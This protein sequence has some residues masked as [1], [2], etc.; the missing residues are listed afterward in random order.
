[1]TA[2]R[3]CSVCGCVE[4]RAC[5]GGCWWVGPNLCSSCGHDPRVDPQFGDRVTVEGE[6]REVE[7]VDS[8]RVIYSWPGKF[9]VRTIYID[10]WRV[11]STQAT[12]WSAGI[13]RERD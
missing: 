5:E 10:A 7:K 8:D 12:A 13:G 2:E 3:A 6:T 4:S 1:M 11:W 9:A